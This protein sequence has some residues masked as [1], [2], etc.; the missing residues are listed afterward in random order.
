[1]YTCEGCHT[2]ADTELQLPGAASLHSGC[3]GLVTDLSGATGHGQSSGVNAVE[4][5]RARYLRSVSCVGIF[6][7]WI[8]KG[9]CDTVVQVH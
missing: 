2:T 6:S 7:M 9:F 8:A 5:E 1:M 3:G 4:C